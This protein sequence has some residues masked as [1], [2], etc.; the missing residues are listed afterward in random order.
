MPTSR[1]RDSGETPKTV[2][3]DNKGRVALGKLAE[4]VSSFNVERQED[5][6]LLLKPQ[7]EIPAYEVWLF[8]NAKA[9]GAVK[10]GLQD[11]KAGRVKQLG[12]FAKFADEDEDG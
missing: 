12:S 7:V 9:L 3:P 1:F 2:R 6:S 10:K 5:G 8:K 11:A 4:G